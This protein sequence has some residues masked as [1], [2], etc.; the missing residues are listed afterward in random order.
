MVWIKNT[1]E[2]EE[3]Y[4]S[5]AYIEELKNNN[6]VEICGGPFEIQIDHR[7]NMVSPFLK[8]AEY[9]YDG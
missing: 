1:L 6:E 9:H 2:L 7:G 4:V 5:E 3:I 8:Q